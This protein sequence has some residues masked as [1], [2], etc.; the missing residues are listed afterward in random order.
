MH[1]AM[2]IILATAATVLLAC[3]D[4]P[5]KEDRIVRPALWWSGL[6]R[7]SDGG[8]PAFPETCELVTDA[9]A[10]DKLWKKLGLKEAHPR[11]NFKDYFVV[12]VFRPFGLDF[13]LGGGLAVDERGDA[14]PRGMRLDADT[15]NSGVYSTTIG[16]FP[17]DGIRSVQGK[18]LPAK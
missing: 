9:E 11:I 3:S 18:K 12:V 13:E 17:R 1:R 8:G 7:M 6:G 10:F 14:Q 16:V 2:L 5:R 4:P 15:M